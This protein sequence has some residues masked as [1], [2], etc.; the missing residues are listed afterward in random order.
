METNLSTE[1]VAPAPDSAVEHRLA[2]ER[3][4]KISHSRTTRYGGTKQRAFVITVR[5]PNTRGVKLRAAKGRPR[6]DKSGQ[7][8]L[9]AK[10]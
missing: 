2:K 7:P 4:I 8:I 3:R 1:T 5:K 6:L 9:W 10:R